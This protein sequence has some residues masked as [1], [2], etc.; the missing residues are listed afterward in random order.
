MSKQDRQPARTVAALEQRYSF[1]KS[2]AEVQGFADDAR[3]AAED[4]QKAADQLDDLFAGDIY[5]T[6]KFQS[7]SEGYLPPTYDDVVHVVRHFVYPESYPIPEGANFDLNGDGV[8]NEDDAT[9][10]LAV[11]N[12]QAKMELC[13]G[14]EKRP[15]TICI[16]MSNA[17]K[18]IRIYGT[19]M[20]GSEVEM[21]IGSDA[22]NSSF[23]SKE[24]MKS[25][26]Q[27]ED[28]GSTYRYVDITGAIT[29]EKEYY[30]PP[31]KVGVEYRT[32]ERWNGSVVYTKLVDCGAVPEAGTEKLVAHGAYD[33]YLVLRC[34]GTLNSGNTL[35]LD[36]EG[37]GTI[38]CM[39]TPTEIILR[40]GAD[41]PSWLSQTLTAHIQIWYIKD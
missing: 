32:T 26:I 16:D 34:T 5:M 13:R 38:S 35:P 3:R 36:R 25:I 14:A 33:I 23:V 39:A 37:Y 30:N 17:E 40:A 6:G 15:V 31:M 28:D 29:G 24:S 4:A 19:N 1:G 8:V 27:L 7:T 22:S 2:F 41:C 11:F 12:G 9:L 18:T 20:W 21:Y 10:T